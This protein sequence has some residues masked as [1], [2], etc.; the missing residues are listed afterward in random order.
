MAAEAAKAFE[1]YHFPQFMLVRCHQEMNRPV[2]DEFVNLISSELKSRSEDSL[3]FVAMDL[4]GW[5]ELS[6]DFFKVCRDLIAL[7]KE[8]D[9]KLVALNGPPTTKELLA[10]SGMDRF[11]MSLTLSELAELQRPVVP[12]SQGHRDHFVADSWA[13]KV[14]ELL[15]RLAP[16]GRGCR[17]IE[18]PRA[19]KMTALEKHELVVSAGLQ[20]HGQAFLIGISLATAGDAEVFKNCNSF[21]KVEGVTAES[22]LREFVNIAAHKTLKNLV[23]LG[24]S[25]ACQIPGEMSA[26]RIATLALHPPQ[27]AVLEYL[28]TRFHCMCVRVTGG[29][30][31]VAKV[32]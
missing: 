3:R 26:H 12:P 31:T 8:G 9:W 2:L 6:A 11:V 23:D 16:E 5:I 30:G 21:P 28:G 18:G 14:S 25:A 27:V 17:V 7:M 22:W 24:F 13:E 4:Q 32:S 29:E 1:V 19:L 10:Q 15:S 20:L